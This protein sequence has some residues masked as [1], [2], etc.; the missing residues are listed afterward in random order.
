MPAKKSE[1]MALA[2][3]CLSALCVAG[4]AQDAPPANETTAPSGPPPDLDDA[5]GIRPSDEQIELLTRR[6]EVNLPDGGKFNT[7]RGEMAFNA[8][9]DEGYPAGASRGHSSLA[10]A[11]P[12]LTLTL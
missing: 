3:L 1:R 6:F 5:A 7:S 12:T 8:G 4:L 2:V 11:S 9:F 10:D